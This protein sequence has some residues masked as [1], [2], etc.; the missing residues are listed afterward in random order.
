MIVIACCSLAP[1]PSRAQHAS[2][3]EAREIEIRGVKVKVPDLVLRDQDSLPVHFYSDLIKD[4]IVVLNFFYTSCTYSCPMQGKTLSEFQALLGERLGKSVFLISVTTD[5]VKDNPQQLKTWATRY[6]VKPGWRL[7]TGDE[8]ELNKLLPQFIGNKAGG[9][10]HE[11]VIFVG[12]DKKGVWTG[13]AGG[14]TPQELLRVVD[15][16]A[17]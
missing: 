4:K 5:P 3:A 13:A 16:L 17:Q 1:L 7:V 12:N 15:Y 11:P 8:A 14:V 6:K 10:M 9:G 2:I